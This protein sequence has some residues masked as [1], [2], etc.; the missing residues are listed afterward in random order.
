LAHHRGNTQDITLQRQ[1]FDSSDP[2]IDYQI[3]IIP[4]GQE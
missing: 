4:P 2:P 3:A 1:F